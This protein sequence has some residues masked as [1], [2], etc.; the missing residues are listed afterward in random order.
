MLHIIKQWKRSTFESQRDPHCKYRE[1]A[2]I[3]P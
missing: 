1:T 3:R 2:K